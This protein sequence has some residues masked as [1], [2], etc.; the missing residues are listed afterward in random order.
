MIVDLPFTFENPHGFIEYTALSYEDILNID[1]VLFETA[2][3]FVCNK[4]NY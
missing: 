1:H 4:D 2:I 3:D